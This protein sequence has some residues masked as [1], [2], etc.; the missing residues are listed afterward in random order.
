V[1]L[2]KV[3]PRIDEE[4]EYRMRVLEPGFATREVIKPGDQLYDPMLGW[5]EPDHSV[6]LCDIG[7]QPQRGWDPA[8]GHG[9]ILRLHADDE[10]EVIVPPEQIGGGMP[11]SPRRAPAHFGSWEGTTF[12]V[13]Q[14]LPGRHGALSG[15]AV[16]RVEGHQGRLFSALPHVGSQGNGIAG[17]LCIG[18]FGP[19]GSA[20]EGSY[21]CNSQMNCV[22]YTVDAD[23]QAEPYVIL[24]EPTMPYPVQPYRVFWAGPAWGELE[25][26]MIVAG[27]ANST[28]EVEAPEGNILKYWTIVDGKI[29]PEPV[30]EADMGYSMIEV[31][32]A[33][34]GPF[35]GHSFLVDFGTVNLMH[36]TKPGPGPL[37]YNSRILRID[38]EGNVH[39][40]ADGLQ[41]GWNEVVFDGSRMIV[42]CLRR[43]YST[44]E[45]HE[46][47]G[48]LY[49][50]KYT[51]TGS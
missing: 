14:T 41:S 39:T 11:M 44:G 8:Q 13:G 16:F 12:Y 31:A 10:L 17:A 5:S 22:I 43:S 2:A 28:F 15:H 46:P 26:T 25:G 27:L 6:I 40:F 42:G 45:Y 20:E 21:I 37:P 3:D 18:G 4:C 48:S 33:E 9:S 30:R 32:P 47:D 35:G 49:E 34:F 7:G 24:D 36:V 38:P 51:G 23:G 29:N 50:V 19:K 1:A